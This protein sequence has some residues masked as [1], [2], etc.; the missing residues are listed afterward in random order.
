MISRCHNPNH[1]SFS[2]Y[3]GRGIAVCER[4]RADFPAFLADM[5]ERPA[6]MTIERMENSLGYEPSNC[7]WATRR[8]QGQ[9]SRHCKLNQEKARAIRADP[10]PY[11]E[12]AAE[13]GI[14]Y[15]Y[16][17]QIKAGRVW[18]DQF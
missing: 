1:V 16:V 14:A 3:G 4:W 7:K 18:K 8:E 17:T 6:G 5:G 10:R 12:I 15:G 9:N 2:Y 11:K 13:Y